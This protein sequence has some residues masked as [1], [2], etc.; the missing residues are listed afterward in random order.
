MHTP[1][2][3]THHPHNWS[4]THSCASP[5][6]GSS[7]EGMQ[8]VGNPLQQEL[9]SAA[10]RTAHTQKLQELRPSCD[11][12]NRA[13]SDAPMRARR[14]SERAMTGS[15]ATTTRTDQHTDQGRAAGQQERQR[16][17]PINSAHLSWSGSQQGRDHVGEDLEFYRLRARSGVQDAIEVK[18]PASAD[19][20]GEW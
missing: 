9:T 17:G 6:R 15:E 16:H 18:T 20:C 4:H 11:R 3:D 7:A 5:A 12:H 8:R 14:A 2:L 1:A 13:A 10:Q 19:E